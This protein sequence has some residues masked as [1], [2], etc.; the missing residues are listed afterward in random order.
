MVI[1]WGDSSQGISWGSPWIH[2]GLLEESPRGSPVPLPQ[3]PHLWGDQ[4]I[5]G[6]WSWGQ[7]LGWYPPTIFPTA[8]FGHPLSTISHIPL[9]NPVSPSSFSLP[10]C[11]ASSPFVV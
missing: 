7:F 4:F 10:I 9:R 8:P 6:G 11:P 3:D 2:R 5:L 1:P